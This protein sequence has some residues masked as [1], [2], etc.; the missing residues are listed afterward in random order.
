MFL[1]PPFLLLHVLKKINQRNHEAKRE[2]FL[3]LGSLE[4]NQGTRTDNDQKQLE[5]SDPSKANPFGKHVPT[6]H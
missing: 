5:Q 2:A 6:N 4:K 1:G 3:Q